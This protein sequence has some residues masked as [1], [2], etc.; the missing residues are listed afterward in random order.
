M[1]VNSDNFRNLS[2]S[3]FSVPAKW[4][5]WSP[6][7]QCSRICGS[8]ATR[9]KVRYFLS[10]R[11]GAREKPVGSAEEIEECSTDTIPDWPTC[12]VVAKLGAWA[13]WSVCNK[14]C[15]KGGSARPM[16]SRQRFCIPE[17]PSTKE[18]LNIGLKTCADLI[19]SKENRPCPVNFCPGKKITDLQQ[20]LC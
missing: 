6:W 9:Q 20:S 2:H 5:D 4:M 7:S 1:D 15:V 16:S 12:P 11:H 18:A 17:V 14:D 19:Y 8:G 13:E 3:V 10:G